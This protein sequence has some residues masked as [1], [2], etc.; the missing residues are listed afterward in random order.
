MLAFNYNSKLKVRYNIKLSELFS[1]SLNASKFLH[2]QV[3]FLFKTFSKFLDIGLYMPV[4]VISV[5]ASGELMILLSATFEL[6][7][8]F[9]FE[10]GGMSYVS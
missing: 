8:I 6:V 10:I 4:Y 7:M 3:S 9:K 5:T 2:Y 1:Y